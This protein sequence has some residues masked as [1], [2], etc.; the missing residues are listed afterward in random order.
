MEPI[1]AESAPVRGRA[2]VLAT[3]LTIAASIASVAAAMPRPHHARWRHHHHLPY[4]GQCPYGYV[5]VP[6]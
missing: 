1:L 6:R 2:L 4:N 5:Y 3:V